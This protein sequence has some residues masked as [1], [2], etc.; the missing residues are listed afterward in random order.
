MAN[1]SIKILLIE[2]D[3]DEVLV[4]REILAQAEGNHASMTFEIEGVDCL[5]VGM[6]RLRQGGIDLI[7]TDLNLPDSGGLDTFKKLQDVAPE[8]PIIILSVFYDD[9]LALEAVRRGAQD[10]LFKKNIDSHLFIRT[11]SYAIE[12][13]RIRIKLDLVTQKLKSA[14]TRLKK[15]ILL[16]PLTELLNRRGLQQVLS[17]EIH[18]IRRGESDLLAVLIDL[19][20]FKRINDRFGHAVGDIVLKEIARKLKGSLRVTDYVARVGGDEFLTLLPATRLPEGLH[21]A[22]KIRL[23]ICEAPITLASGETIKITASIGVV[24]VFE[25]I[26]SIDELLSQTHSVLHQ[27]K[28]T[29]KNRVSFDEKKSPGG[30]GGNNSLTEVLSALRQPNQFHA[31]KQ[32]IFRFSD[33]EK[34]G[35]EFL[36]RSWVKGFEMPD[37][38]FRLSLEAD[39]L[40]LVDHQCFK[41]CIAAGS[42]LPP[43]TKRHLNLFPSTLISIPVQHLLEP[44]LT[45]NQLNYCIEIS[46]QQI[47]G[48]PSYLVPV[49][50]AFKR[51]GICIAIDDVGFG[52]SCLESLV[53][54]E[55][56]IIKI[57]KRWVKGVARTKDHLQSLKRLIKIAES[58]DAEVIAEGIE[59]VE[60]LNVLKDLGVKY[61]QGFLLGRPA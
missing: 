16:D 25:E 48:D 49:V 6:E 8:I 1:Q 3:Q 10:Y 2:D 17:R 24:S 23:A 42:E 55:P 32:P 28:S 57:D 9:A 56:D 14:N 36:S 18:W 40:T 5:E 58:L 30:N 12:R 38:F 43:E 54:L 31:L 11:I 4:L 22:E 7:L 13:N 39:M 29:G 41:T 61:G 26:V 20:D 37:D 45:S 47:I 44:F 46:E 53:L 34:V 19:D 15:L 59:T 52:R 60:D 21:V 51:A 27:S 35:Y 33:E 50:L